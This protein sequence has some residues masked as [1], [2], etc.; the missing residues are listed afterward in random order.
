VEPSEAGKLRKYGVRIGGSTYIPFE[1][2]RKLERQLE[3]IVSKASLIQD[4]YEQSIFLLVHVSYLQ[5]FIDVNKRTARLCANIPLIKGNL[6]PLAFSDV[7]V[8]DYMSAMIAIYELQEVQPLVDLYVYSYMRTSAAYDSTV[9]AMGFDEVRVRYRQE[10]KKVVRD[11]ILQGLTGGNLRQHVEE[12]AARL[13]PDFHYGEFVED[14][15]EDLVQMDESRS[16]GLGVTSEQLRTWQ[17]L[18]GQQM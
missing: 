17:R 3:K 4:P 13:I 2:P 11:A 6:V 1:D 8:A 7:R 15:I 18:T 5:A 9:K 10:R 12:V 14:V 16:A